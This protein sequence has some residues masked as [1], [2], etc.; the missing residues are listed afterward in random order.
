MTMPS[1]EE[2]ANAGIDEEALERAQRPKPPVGK[3]LLVLMLFVGGAGLGYGAI[4]MLLAG[5]SV[6]SVPAEV[7]TTPNVVE[8]A[9]LVAE[10]EA[11]LVA[12]N[13]AQ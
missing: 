5:E 11:E 12:L 2:L 4:H 6:E 7:T 9:E 1:F 3:A 10:P 8:T 13:L